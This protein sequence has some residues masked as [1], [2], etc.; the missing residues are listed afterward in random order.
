MENAV[1]NRKIEYVW[2]FTK[3]ENLDSILKNGLIPRAYLE[4]ENASVEY[5]DSYRLDECKDANCLS[6]GHPNYKMFYRLRQNNPRQEWVIIIVDSKILWSKECAF[7]YENAAS[8]KVTCIPIL[9]RKSVKSFESLF[10][11]ADDKPDR[12]T[13][14]LPDDCPT[15]PQ[16]E[17]LVFG[18][19]EPEYIVGAIVSSKERE[20]ELKEI[21]PDFAFVY[22]KGFYS[23]RL[24]YTHW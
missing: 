13:L 8:H 22:N 6:I 9:I 7:C 23:P 15:N 2:H 14:G 20:N 18:L 16:A 3:I 19:I 12:Q 1:R 17:V 21:Y 4:A 10:K 24:D 5:N 11:P